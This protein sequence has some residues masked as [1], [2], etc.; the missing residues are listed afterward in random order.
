MPQ[1][2]VKNGSWEPALVIDYHCQ[3]IGIGVP[4]FPDQLCKG[5]ISEIIKINLY[6]PVPSLALGVYLILFFLSIHSL[7]LY[8]GVG[9]GV[10]RADRLPRL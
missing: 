1:C 10:L 4:V 2:T 7:Y 9:A 3:R 5:H 8:V 6:I